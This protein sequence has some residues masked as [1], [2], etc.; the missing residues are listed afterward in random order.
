MQLASTEERS[1]KEERKGEMHVFKST[2]PGY[3]ITADNT[4]QLWDAEYG[5]PWSLERH[6]QLNLTEP[7]PSLV[8]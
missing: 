8:P 5:V 1:G 2:Q 7:A 6:L 3:E 4:L